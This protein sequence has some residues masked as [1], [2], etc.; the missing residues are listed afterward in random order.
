MLGAI[1][2]DDV[3]IDLHLPLW[4]DTL[5][6]LGAAGAI[7]LFGVKSARYADQL[8]DKTGM[9]EAITGTVLLGLL[10]A[11]PGLVASVVAAIDGHAAMAI[12][13]AMGGIAFQTVALVVA[14]AAYRGTNL[15]HAAASVPNMV[16]TGMLILLLTLVVGGLAGPRVTLGHVSPM[17][18]LLFAAA[19]FAFWVVFRTQGEPMWSPKQTGQTVED[20]P[21]EKHQQ[22]SATWMIVGI[23]VAGIVTIV[24]GALVAETAGEF[25]D[26]G[27]TRGV[28][29]GWPVHGDCDLV[30]RVG[31]Q[32]GGCP[33]R[34]RH[35]RGQ[36]HRGRQFL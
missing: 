17:T 36:R 10:T 6:F 32:R 12:S 19:G 8:A 2:R 28:G 30:A 20:V 9:G 1:V 26:E 27:R 22:A 33:P 13:N 11:L 31:H 23:L 4:A 7:G 35:A 24:S 16:Q 3:V 14:D 5:A 29:G 15:E 34:C 18:L 25:T 21:D